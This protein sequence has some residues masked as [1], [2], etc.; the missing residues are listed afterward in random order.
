MAR[1]LVINDYSLPFSWDNAKHRRSPA[2]FL[3]GVDHLAG[4]GH[5]VQIVSDLK[6]RWMAALDRHAGRWGSLLGSLD[7]QTAALPFLWRTDLIYSP[8]Q[9]QTQVL[10]YMRAVGILRTPIICLAHHPIVRGQFGRLTRPFTQ[11]MLNG[12]SAMP[13]L[14]RTV[15]NEINT[16]S[17]R[18]LSQPLRW[19]PDAGFYPPAQ[20]PGIGALAAGRTGRDFVTFGRAATVTRVPATILCQRTALQAE[21]E[22]FGSN[23]RVTVPEL[24]L[25]YNESSRLFASAR[26]L[27]IPMVAQDSL[28]G[29]SSLM[30]VLGAGKPVIMTR[31]AN[32]DLD[33]EALGIGRWVEP[34]DVAGWTNALRFFED[35]PDAATEMGRRARALT[36]EGYNYRAFS[37]DIGRL[38]ESVLS[39]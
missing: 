35:H 19:G 11:L 20:Y 39:R 28:V 23:V 4:A 25:E 5:Q 12:L 27:A 36:E 3:Y 33:I 1:I 16:L 2:H 7:R 29:L 6:T 22:T 9:T 10:T 21:F 8:C 38:V 15:A 13:A 24:F 17:G 34:G 30:D 37:N 18:R 14:S 32:I 26:V 31:N